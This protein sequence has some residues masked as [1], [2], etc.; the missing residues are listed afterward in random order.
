VFCVRI[1]AVPKKRVLP[2]LPPET[3]AQ[4]YSLAVQ[5]ALA[6]L[7]A[8]S[9]LRSEVPS[10]SLGIAQLGQEELGKSL[11]LLASVGLTRN[12]EAW[13]WFWDSWRNH[14]V[15]AHR[16]YLYELIDPLRIEFR[17]SDGRNYDG[18]PLRPSIEQEK[19]ASFYVDYDHQAG[20]FVAP[21]AAVA[22]EEATSRVLTLGYLGATAS[23]IHDTL[24]ETQSAF[25]L[26]AFSEVAF[27]IC[28][29]PLMQ[30]DMPALLDNFGSR[31]DRHREL[32][33]SMKARFAINRSIWSAGAPK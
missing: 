24:M 16:A 11:S 17:G 31:S 33:I 21:L 29:E 18:G 4:G 6:L 10:V 8:A 9:S 14:T 7:D 30:E 3:S 32:L 23:A 15:K 20:S 13:K 25:R 28:T 19:E 22:S 27:R 1:A 5:N 12:D 2:Q 26:G